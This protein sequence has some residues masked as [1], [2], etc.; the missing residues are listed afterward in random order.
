MRKNYIMN[1]YHL[2]AKN[3]VLNTNENVF[4]IYSDIKILGKQESINAVF[5]GEVQ[6]LE[7]VLVAVND[8]DDLDKIYEFTQ[9]TDRSWTEQKKVVEIGPQPKRSTSVGDLIISD[10]GDIWIVADFGFTKI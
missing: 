4:K 6:D 1:V 5:N 9:H 2:V 10:G 7:Y 3:N 8:T